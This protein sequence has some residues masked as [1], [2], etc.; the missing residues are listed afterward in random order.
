M[1][2]RDSTICILN[3]YFVLVGTAGELVD[4]ASEH[5]QVPGPD[6]SRLLLGP[7]QAHKYVMAQPRTGLICFSYILLM[8]DLFC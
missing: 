5:N 3:N 4:A 8:S 7:F 1:K 2:K 6:C